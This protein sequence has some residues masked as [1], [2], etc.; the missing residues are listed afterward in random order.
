MAKKKENKQSSWFK[1]FSLRKK[2]NSNPEEIDEIIQPEGFEREL[3]KAKKKFNSFHLTKNLKVGEQIERKDYKIKKNGSNLYKLESSNFQIVLITGNSLQEKDGLTTGVLQIQEADLSRALQREHSDLDS[4]L[5]LWKPQLP[6]NNQDWKQILDWPI[7]WKQHILLRLRPDSL[8]L[9][10]VCLDRDFSDFFL[11]M[12][13]R[14]QKKI[15]L[16]ELFYLNQGKNSED[17]NPHTKNKTL[18][19]PDKAIHEL[20]Q[21]IDSI[22]VKMD[23]EKER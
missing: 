23:K 2:K 22:K 20:Y 19:Y 10:T 14:K 9:L 16:D 17:W 3:E 12:A 7:F 21:T 11:E 4:F 5:E 6:Q 15:L 8:A 1:F 13:T 18:L